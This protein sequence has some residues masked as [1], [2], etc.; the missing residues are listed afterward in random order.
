MRGIATKSA[1]PF[2]IA[3]RPPIAAARGCERAQEGQFGEIPPGCG[4]TSRNECFRSTAAGRSSGARTTAC[5]P[6]FRP[7]YQASRISVSWTAA[8]HSAQ[9]QLRAGNANW[10]ALQG[11]FSGEGVSG[12]DAH[13]A[14]SRVLQ[15][16]S[17]A[18]RNHPGTAGVH[19]C[20]CYSRSRNPSPERGRAHS[21]RGTG[22]ADNRRNGDYPPR[23]PSGP[24]GSRSNGTHISIS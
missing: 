20:L 18:W 7:G 14:H 16:R 4:R 22:P 19:L 24:G 6:V 3:K 9:P 17:C 1:Q 23:W 2:R 21:P 10:R 8:L 11:E 12:G 13:V 5:V 15:R